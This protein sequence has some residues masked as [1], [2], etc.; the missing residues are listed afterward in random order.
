[1]TRVRQA[2]PSD[3]RAVRDAHVAAIEA[4]GPSAYDE[5]QVA[6]WADR[7]DA[8]PELDGLD[9]PETY[10]VVAER[11]GETADRE[12]DERDERDGPGDR[13]STA[14]TAVVAGFGRF[15]VADAEVT[16]VYVHP[17]HARAGVGSTLLAHL[18]GFARGLGCTSLT[19]RSSLNA[20]E[21]YERAGYERV[22]EVSHETSGG[23]TLTCVDMEKPL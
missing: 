21:F 13:S 2:R 12:A 22:A 1:M 5:A 11:A 17:D 8:D 20:V 7:E 4:Y 6:S 15:D 10:L 14:S 19:L 16:A 3:A 23:A 9:D 18:E